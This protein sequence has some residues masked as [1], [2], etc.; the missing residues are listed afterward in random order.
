MYK[1]IQVL[2]RPSNSLQ[3]LW[4]YLTVPRLLA[5]L[6][7]GG[8][9]F[10]H[11]PML[12]DQLEGALTRRT[13]DR[14][15]RHYLGLGQPLELAKRQIEDYQDHRN[16][17]FVNCWHINDAESYLMW[18]VYGDRGCAIQT[19]FERL[20]L[21][22]DLAAVE[23]NGTVVKYVDFEREALP[24]GN[25]YTAVST[26]DQPYRD[27]R[28]FRLFL[29]Q[30]DQLGR[31]DLQRAPGLVVPVNLSALIERIYLSPRV[32][33]H[34]GIAEHIRRR[35]LSCEIMSSSVHER[36]S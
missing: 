23:I 24:V 25:I 6:E 1:H 26:K 12:S 10:A 22:L 32:Q 21:A 2:Q 11:L 36:S 29:W 35:G 33:N 7:S 30:P 15:L 34:A 28:E 18:R 17:F 16:E 3:Q 5:L 8:L 4:R 27:E 14:L 13:H 31:Q 9:Y 19:T 20:Q